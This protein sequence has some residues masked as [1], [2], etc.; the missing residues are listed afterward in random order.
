MFVLLVC[1]ITSAVCWLKFGLYLL[2]LVCFIVVLL[3]GLIWGCLCHYWLV[4]YG[5]S[6]DPLVVVQLL[7]P[8]W[9]V[10][11]LFASV[12]IGLC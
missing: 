2:F 8:L 3:F 5:Y 10:A 4:W 12:E 11:Y 6:P 1:L 7:L 9:I